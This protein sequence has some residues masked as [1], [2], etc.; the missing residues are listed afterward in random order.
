MSDIISDIRRRA[1]ELLL[2]QPGAP[3]KIRPADVQRVVHELR[4]HQIELEM[5]IDEL[6][7]AQQELQESREKYFDLYDKAPVGYVTL[8]ENGIILEANLTA[9]SLLS[10]E[11]S[12]L[13]RQPFTQFITGED[14]DMYYFCN[15][16]LMETREHQECEVRMLK[17]DGS[18]LWARL[19]SVFAKGGDGETVYRTAIIDI[20]RRKHA[21]D[22]RTEKLEDSIKTRTSELTTSKEHYE[23]LNQTR[24]ALEEKVI[25]QTA[26]ITRGGAELQAEV[27]QRRLAEDLT[28]RLAS[29][30]QL[31]P[32][33]VIEVDASGVVLF[34]NAAAKT[35]LASLGMDKDDVTAFL[36]HDIDS[37]LRDLDK[38]EE[39]S[40]DRELTLRGKVFSERLYL[41]PQFN[42]VRIYAVDITERRKAEIELLREVSVRKQ[43]EE[44]M[45]LFIEHAPA[46]LAMFDRE[47]R[48]L[49]VS[50]RWL[51]D[52]NLENRELRGVSHYEVFPEIPECWK[53]IH[54]RAL[55]GEVVSDDNARFDRADG[56]VQWLRWEVRPW[57]DAAGDVAG[58][59]IFSEDI[60]EHKRAEEALRQLNDTLERKVIQRTRFYTFVAEINEAIVR[61]RDRQ[62]L[63]GEVCRIIVETGGFKLAWIGIVDATSREVRQE[64]SCGETSYLEGIRIIAADKPEGRGPTGRAITEGRHIINSDFE[65][66]PNMLPWRERAHA[67]GIRSSSAFPLRTEGHVIGA[68][69][70]YSDKPSYF[71]DEEISLLL[72]ITDNIAFAL[73]AISAEEKRREAEEALAQL[74][75][76]LEQRVAERTADLEVAIKELEA[77]NYS[78][79]HDLRAPLR[80]V[81]GFSELL[82]KKLV[83]HPDEKTRNYANLIFDAT[84]KM[85]ILIDHLLEFSRLGRS[86]IQKTK[87]NLNELVRRV[88][89]EIQEESEGRKIQWDIDE[90]PEV[91]G[92]RTLLR[93]VMVNLLSNA[94]KFT[95]TRPQAEIRIGCKDE[96]DIFTCS[97]SDNGVG[98]DMKYADRLFGVFQRLHTQKDFEGT[99]I[100]LANVQRIIARHGG[101]VWAESAVGHGATFHFTLPN[102]K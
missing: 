29:F 48:Y 51:R 85:G 82:L 41:T 7:R 57:Y 24:D 42:A 60:T 93:L 87:V 36:P 30:P 61:H 53:A 26:E 80:H 37:I 31:N 84:K 5:Q 38:D 98:F 95:R 17:G 25:Q 63:L 27:T 66:D 12:S 96:G 78:V 88:V 1:E 3:D 72:S 11:R 101:K 10:Q 35:V 69:T 55:A 99:G 75:A 54:R 50:R 2:K 83:D 19:E 68:L 28:Q 94:V 44:Q 9:V 59:V 77:F 32:N 64:E 49:R 34:C 74:N 16:R 73:D 8:N 90:L 79:S 81:S 45:R 76:E 86:E 70:I 13:V 52:Y 91:L 20:T 6:H 40:H 33:P 23:A 4:V 46:A 67:H 22:R 14:Q 71:A 39:L 18:H 47:M 62:Q 15:K 56:S 100:G 58:I 89:Q 97:I 65:E 21:E 92:D 102:M 43:S